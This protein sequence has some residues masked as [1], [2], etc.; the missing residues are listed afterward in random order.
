MIPVVAQITAFLAD[1]LTVHIAKRNIGF[2]V[3]LAAA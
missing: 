3:K 1:Q 2:I